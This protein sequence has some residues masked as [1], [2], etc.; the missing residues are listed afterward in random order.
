[1]Y[2]FRKAAALL[3][4]LV[5]L[6]GVAVVPA[7]AANS[8]FSINEDGVLTGY[9]GPGGDVVIP[10]GVTEI[11]PGAFSGCSAMTSVTIPNSVTFIGYMAFGGCTGLTSVE[12]PGYVTEIVD[13][14]F[15]Y[16]TGLTSVTIPASVTEIGPGVFYKC[17][18]LANVT[19][20][21]DPPVLGD[22]VF[23]GTPWQKSMGDFPVVDGTLL[24]YLGNGGEVVIPDTVTAI[25]DAAF[26]KNSRITSVVIPDSVKSIGRR[27]FYLCSKLTRVTIGRGVTSIAD[28]AFEDSKALADV[29]FLGS[30]PSI[31]STAFKGTAWERQN[32][33]AGDFV[34]VNGTLTH[35]KGSGGDVVVPDGITAIGSKAFSYNYDNDITS[36]TLPAGVTQIGDSAFYGCRH[37]TDVNLPDG[38]TRIGES[39]FIGCRALTSIDLPDGLTSIGASAFSGCWGLTSIDL[40]DSVTEIGKGA[41]SDCTGLTTFN[42][43][44]SVTVIPAKM[45][46][47]CTGLT[48]VHYP[49][50]LTEIGDSAFY[51]CKS[52]P[53]ITIPDSVTAIGE[54]AFSGC[55]GA[56]TLKIP[57]SGIELG[58]WAFPSYT[59]NK[60]NR[61]AI[62]QLMRNQW[63]NIGSCVK[64]QSERIT[65]FSNKLTAGL[66]S[67]YEKAKAIC[68]WVS[69]NI[70]YDRDYYYYHEKDYSDVPFDPEDVLDARLA[71]CAGYSNLTRALLQ[72][73]GIPTLYVLGDAN[74]AK[75]WDDHAWNEAYIDGR[76]ILIDTTWGPEYFDMSLS[77]FV[78]KHGVG[79]RVTVEKKDIPSA[80]AKDEVRKAMDAGLIPD[81]MQADYRSPI[82]RERFCRLMVTLVEQITGQDIDSYIASRGLSITDP[83][84]DTD[85]PEVLAAYALRIAIGNS[86]TTFDP[87]GRVTRQEAATMLARTARLLGLTAGSGEAFADSAHFSSWAAQ[88]IA[89]IS[90]LTDPTTGAKVMNGTGNGLFS[91]L[92]T[93]TCEQAI[94]TSLRLFHCAEGAIAA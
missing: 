92:D 40:P 67:D 65:S 84:T 61:L 48:S 68:K 31:D 23:T 91:P 44:D 19:F 6:L 90:G 32:Q 75:G 2:K 26:F 42:F 94:M 60:A 12:I 9:Y 41:F 1:M 63:V 21:G 27:A 62:Y 85:T 4:A 24:A 16:C 79:H 55:T 81:D 59:K 83:F 45:L 87:Y 28:H 77:N 88:S 29:V 69:K 71:V 86:D 53:S 52:L 73:Q 20:E 5:L 3:L 38:L 18:S 37:L 8:D 46:Y 93:Y 35:Y 70:K 51:D 82:T 47:N 33:T 25:G 17:S 10:G 72:A 13:Y 64:P 49:N 74:G 34:V 36:V 78:K 50:R 89:L 57:T 58:S 11:G 54:G 39:A 30:V 7:S 76:W 80:W 43:S 22:N 56:K 14:A 66:T 15:S